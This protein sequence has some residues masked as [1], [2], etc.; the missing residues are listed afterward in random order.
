MHL[1]AR[2]VAALPDTGIS[3]FWE[4]SRD[5][6]PSYW[7]STTRYETG[8]KDAEFWNDDH[9]SEVTMREKLAAAKVPGRWIELLIMRFVQCQSLEDIAVALGYFDRT[10]VHRALGSAMQRAKAGGYKRG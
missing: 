6:D 3:V 4:S 1:G 9:G 5:P 7:N 2:E 10:K 8:Y